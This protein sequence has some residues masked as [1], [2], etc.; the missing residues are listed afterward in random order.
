MIGMSHI[1]SS[2][3]GPNKISCVSVKVENC[4]I[5]MPPPHTQHNVKY[6][7]LTAIWTVALRQPLNKTPRAIKSRA[8]PSV[9]MSIMTFALL[10][11]V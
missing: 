7:P 6:K 10:T 3:T 5:H 8:P 9:S 4:S 1:S 11:I 2:H